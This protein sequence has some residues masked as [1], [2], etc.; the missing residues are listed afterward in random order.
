MPKETKTEQSKLIT[1]SVIKADIGGWVG[2]SAIHPALIE[3]AQERLANAKTSGL[4][5]DYHVTACGDD[6][7]LIMT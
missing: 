7:Q 3:S 1:L 5:V 6:L 2:H 4:V